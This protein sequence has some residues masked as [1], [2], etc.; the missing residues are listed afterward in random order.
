MRSI[1]ASAQSGN[2][3][4]IAAV[5]RTLLPERRGRSVA[6]DFGGELEFGG[7]VSQRALA[8]VDR[9]AVQP[10]GERDRCGVTLGVAL[11]S[12]A[13]A[14]GGFLA[15]AS[16]PQLGDQ[17]RLFELQHGAEN[18]PN[19]RRGPPVVKQGVGAGGGDQRDAE[20]LKE[21]KAG[22]AICRP[23]QQAEYGRAAQPAS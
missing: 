19:H 4:A 6:I 12:A 7:Y 11:A 14:G 3:A 18:R 5:A 9:I 2:P 17:R 16:G 22:L 1:V 23:D 20:P 13:F 21:S 10:L 8:P 15:F